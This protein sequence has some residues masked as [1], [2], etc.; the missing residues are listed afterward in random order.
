MPELPE[1]ETIKR[2]L[3]LKLG[4]RTIK[5]ATVLFPGI[6]GSPS[7]EQFVAGLRNARVQGLKRRGKFLL[8]ELAAAKTL[9][10][11]FRMTGRLIYHPAKTPPLDHTHVVFDL[12]GEGQVH[13]MDT[14]KF[15]RLWL[16]P[17]TALPQHTSLCRLGREPLEEEFTRE[18]LRLELR[19]HRTRIKSLL[20][21][22]TFIAGLGNIYADE[23]LHL[24]GLHPEKMARDLSP[25]EIA[26]LHRA[27]QR[28]LQDGIDHNGTTLR[29][30]LDGTGA[31]GRHQDYLKVHRRTGLPCPVCGTKISRK[32]VGGRSTHFCPCCQK[33]S[34]HGE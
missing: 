20:L 19:H 1:V 7:P 12:D 31:A 17:N 3:E 33:D 16:L 34:E 10:I 32:K 27:I 15:G 9:V 4:G 5:E 30:Y 18:F 8:I 25:T 6:I 24:A 26:R 22:Q 11:H 2:T 13:F 14:R 23:A 28:V 21:D 29:D